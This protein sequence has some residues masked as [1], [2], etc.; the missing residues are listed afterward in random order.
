MLILIKE[1]LDYRPSNKSSGLRVPLLGENLELY[2]VWTNRH[3][4]I[5]EK[6]LLSVTGSI[7]SINL[8]DL[9]DIDFLESLS[10]IENRSAPGAAK[11]ENPLALS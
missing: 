11:L 9:S 3:E 6:K 5:D 8:Q 10:S 7:E 4:S 2:L 1:P